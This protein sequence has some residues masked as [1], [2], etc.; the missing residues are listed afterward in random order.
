MAQSANII[1]QA[2]VRELVGTIKSQFIARYKDDTSLHDITSTT[3]LKNS[4][5]LTELQKLSQIIKAH[6]TKLGI[7]CQ[8][9][10]FFHNFPAVYKEL[11]EFT[12]SI[13][14][15]LS[16]LPLFYRDES[17]TW[18]KFLLKKLDTYLLHLLSGISSLCNEIERMLEEGE[19]TGNDKNEDDERLY[20]V[21]M[22]WTS[23][24]SLDDLSKKGSFGL[25]GDNIR[26]SCDLV[27][28]VLQDIDTWLE[29]PHFGNE[30]LIDDDFSDSGNEEEIEHKEGN[31]DEIAALARMQSFVEKWK[32]NLK[33][34]KL[35]LSSF[36][37]SLSSSVYK[38]KDAKGS[39]LDDLYT[40]QLQIVEQIDEFVSDIFMSDASF[41]PSDFDENI[42][43]LNDSLAKMVRIIEK[44]NKSDPKRAKWIKVWENKYFEK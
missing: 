30:F 23:C 39:T 26:N 33:M 41:L 8:P 11:Q 27:D 1:D 17:D 43:L 31:K 29:D 2:K 44:L 7:I 21:G 4:D 36:T 16:L 20:S 38:S 13:F 18:P 28:D 3:N 14:Y 5:P 37:K 9:D 35:L 6:S 12:N 10:R 19:G 24:D 32:T 22:I 42:S 25:L 15:L 34:V 40:L